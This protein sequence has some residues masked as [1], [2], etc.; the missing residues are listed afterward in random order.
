MSPFALSATP[1]LADSAPLV[2][3][4]IVGIIMA[5]HGFQKL[6]AGPGAFGQETLAGLGV[7]FPTLAGYGVIF[8]ELVGGVLLILGLL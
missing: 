7:P 6:L 8:V 3:R 5:A 2:A 1:R 4:V